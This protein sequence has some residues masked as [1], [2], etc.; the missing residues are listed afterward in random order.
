MHWISCI[1]TYTLAT[2]IICTLSY[3]SQVCMVWRTE[4]FTCPGADPFHRA[5]DGSSRGIKRL[6]WNQTGC[7]NIQ[8]QFPQNVWTLMGRKQEKIKE[9][10]KEE[11]EKFEDNREAWSL[12]SWA[13]F[14]LSPFFLYKPLW[15]GS[16]A[17]RGERP[18]ATS[19]PHSSSFHHVTFPSTHV[20]PTKPSFFTSLS[21][22]QKCLLLLSFLLSTFILLT[23]FP[24]YSIAKISCFFSKLNMKPGASIT[25]RI[26]HSSENCSYFTP[27]VPP[28]CFP[29]TP[30]EIPNLCRLKVC[31]LP[32]WDFP[33]CPSRVPPPIT[34]DAPQ[35][36]MVNTCWDQRCY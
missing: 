19:Q 4:Y 30:Q 2:Q 1:H 17:R 5:K 16:R 36:G 13:F 34:A 8:A 32:S 20:L 27:K 29:L 11:K 9:A 28:P 21:L 12:M 33:T 31:L 26:I 25:L 6:A 3:L 18:V 24:S 10:T 7:F 23:N 14:P 15:K 22:S 35:T